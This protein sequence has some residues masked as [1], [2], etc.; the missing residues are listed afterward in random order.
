MQVEIENNNYYK[1]FKAAFPQ[2]YHLPLL[3][4]AP[5]PFPYRITHLLKA[6]LQRPSSL[7]A[8]SVAT[9]DLP[10]GPT[11]RV[12]VQVEISLSLCN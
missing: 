8:E 9:A 7:S 5:L 2:T 4:L 12:C 10:L 3:I 6:T 11:P 1:T